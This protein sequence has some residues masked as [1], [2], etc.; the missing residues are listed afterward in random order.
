MVIMK[1]YL[2]VDLDTAR[3]SGSSSDIVQLIRIRVISRVS[4]LTS[5]VGRE[6]PLQSVNSCKK[7]F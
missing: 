2:Q 6:N 5:L 1:K 4:N 3:M 7:L